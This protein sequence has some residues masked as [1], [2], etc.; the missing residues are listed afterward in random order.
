[1]QLSPR[2]RPAIGL[3]RVTGAPSASFS[4]PAFRPQGS[5]SGPPPLGGPGLGPRP[6]AG[7]P[8]RTDRTG[9]LQFGASPLRPDFIALRLTAAAHLRLDAPQPV[10]AQ[11]PLQRPHLPVAVALRIMGHQALHQR[12]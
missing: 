12:P 3:L 7:R 2:E 11:T 10:P 8:N 6:G 9:A 5:V 1:M 4:F